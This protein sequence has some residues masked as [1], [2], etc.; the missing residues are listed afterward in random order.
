MTRLPSSVAVIGAG[1]YGLASAAHLRGAGVPVQVFGD[2]MSFWSQNMPAGML[3]RSPWGG[4]HISD[5]DGAYTLDRFQA[6]GQIEAARNIPLEGF[7]RYGK[8][9]QSQ[10]AP[11]VD[12]RR[13]TRVERAPGGF[14]LTLEE[15]VT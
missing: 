2:P 12:R 1:P 15:G 3:L 8:W 7:V 5:P 14:E 13:V 6:D 10:V 4:S 9:V 11:D